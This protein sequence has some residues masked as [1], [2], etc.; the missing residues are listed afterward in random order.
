MGKDLKGKELGP[1]LLQRKNGKYVARFQSVSNKRVEKTFT[2]VNEA[3]RWLA[4]KKFEDRHS[5]IGS[6]TSMTVNAWFEYWINNIKMN[7]VRHTT[8]KNYI[9][10]YTYT[11]KEHLGNMIISEVRPMHCQNVINIMNSKGYSQSTMRQSKITMHAMF[12]SAVENEIIL[13]NPVTK[14]VKCP[15]AKTKN[16]NALTLSEQEKL[17]EVASN[18]SLYYHYLFVL[19]TGL[20]VGELIGLQWEDV[21]FDKRTIT[22]S[23]AAHFHTLNDMR[24]GEPKSASSYRTIPLTDS[25]YNILVELRKE[26]KRNKVINLEYKNFVFLNRKDRPTT[27]IVY[28]N[29]LAK[30][31]KKAGIEKISIHVLRHTFATRCIEA[32]MRPKT[33]QKLLGHSNI[34]ITMNLYVH[35]TEESKEEEMK[36][37]QQYCKMA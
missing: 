24:M 31:C 25:A 34:N 23:R 33:V 17:L 37:F 29:M 10:R 11:I 36:K 21:N 6:S 13:K 32:G 28:N 27:N 22:I 5:N 14:S 16:V 12:E 15:T 3:K 8:L 26:R 2:K 30:L 9:D 19:Q 18:S 1:G 20:R 35:V 4:E 7:T